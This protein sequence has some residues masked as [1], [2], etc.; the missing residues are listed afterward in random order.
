MPRPAPVLLGTS[1]F[2]PLF[3]GH[4]NKN[5]PRKPKALCAV[6]CF[7]ANLDRL[8]STCILKDT[9]VTLHYTVTDPDGQLVDDGEHP[10][11]Y[12]H[13]GYD[14]I[15]SVIEEALHQ[16]NVGEQV[17]VKL[18][19]EEAFGPYDESLVLVEELSM[20]PENLEVGMSFERIVD[21]EGEEDALYRVTDIADGKV[22]VDGNHP[23]AGLALT[24]DLTVADVRPATPL[25]LERGHANESAPS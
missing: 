9:V 8:M 17:R 15:F 22:V 18:T 10:L 7:Y 20:F 2:T 4:R 11:V 5:T 21:D 12:L 24:F 25:E 6:G 14:G 23:L 3:L 1:P 16:K 13:G 19:P